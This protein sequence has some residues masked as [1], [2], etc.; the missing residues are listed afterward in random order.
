M[1]YVVL[2]I[3]GDII[4]VANS[5]LKAVFIYEERYGDIE[6]PENTESD[7]DKFEYLKSI[8]RIRVFPLNRF[9]YQ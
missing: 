8:Y 1:V 6:Y 2:N 4:G 5:E 7:F 3:N 9:V